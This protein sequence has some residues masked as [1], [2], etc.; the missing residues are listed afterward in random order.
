MKIFKKLFL[1]N[2]WANF[3]QI[4]HNASFGE[5]DSSLFKWRGLPIFKGDNKLLRNSK[6]KLTK[7]KNPLLQN[8]LLQSQFQPTRHIASLVE[9]DLSFFKWREPSLSKGRW[10]RNSKNKLMKLKNPILQKPWANFKQ[11]WNKASLGEGYSTF[12]KWRTN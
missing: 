11:S 6:I 10:L 9:G 4:W 5:G 2:Y 8:H 3:N 7:L 12:F 1:Q